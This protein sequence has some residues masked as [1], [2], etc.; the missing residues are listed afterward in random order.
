MFFGSPHAN[1]LWKFGAR[2][3]W[4]MTDYPLGRYRPIQNGIRRDEALAGC[5]GMQYHPGHDVV[6]WRHALLLDAQGGPGT[7]RRRDRIP[8]A[9]RRYS[10]TLLE[11][12]GLVAGDIAVT[13]DLPRVMRSQVLT[14]KRGPLSRTVEVNG[15]VRRT[16]RTISRADTRPYCP[17]D[18]AAPLHRSGRALWQA[19]ARSGITAI[20]GRRLVSSTRRYRSRSPSQSR[21]TC[22]GSEGPALGVVSTWEP[23]NA[24]KSLVTAISP[25][26][27]PA[28]PGASRVSSAR[29]GIDPR[30]PDTSRA[31]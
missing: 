25:A 16:Y 24:R 26:T 19:A 18:D 28:S 8:R 3:D 22:G 29:L 6:G 15:F 1:A 12:A 20:P 21:I 13:K 23:H 14:T 27:S 11:V 4:A 5:G 7:C 30:R 31:S 9:S 2:E 17:V 10:R